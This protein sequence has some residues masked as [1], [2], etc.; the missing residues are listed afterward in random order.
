MLKIL[1]WLSLL[2]VRVIELT[3]P[4][5]LLRQNEKE[6]ERNTSRVRTMKRSL[7]AH[8]LARVQSSQIKNLQNEKVERKK[9]H[10]G[11]KKVE[12]SSATMCCLLARKSF[13]TPLAFLLDPYQNSC[14]VVVVDFWP[15][16]SPRSR[17]R[18][19][20]I[21]N[22]PQLQKLD[23]IAVQPDEMAD[24]MRRGIELHWSGNPH[25]T[26]P[27]PTTTPRY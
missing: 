24:A 15:F 2:S 4:R 16:F 25:P 3:A 17:Y 23:N 8:L 27:W 22:L 14:A 5:G 13:Q 18:V 20:V 12:E 10:Q 7:L 21:R 9:A 19:T 1:F 11:T 6:S 26:K